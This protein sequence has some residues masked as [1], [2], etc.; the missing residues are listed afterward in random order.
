M[1]ATHA[2]LRSGD[3]LPQVIAYADL[4]DEA[5]PLLTPDGDARA[6]LDALVAGELFD[7]AVALL[8]HVLPV[9]EAVWWAWTCAG[10]SAGEKPV[11]GIAASLEATR[12]WIIEPSDEHRRA[13]M[14]A[15][16]AAGLD[17]PA[18]LAGLSAFLSGGSLAPPEAPPAPP[19]PHIAGKAIAGCVCMA[20]VSDPEQIARRF[21][22]FIQKGL[23]MA[24]KRAVWASPAPAQAKR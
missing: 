16:E 1:N 15:A 8:A 22:A 19:E 9:R 14:A 5:A 6:F 20:A 12:Q 13:A 10:E 17:S 4:S 23:E 18:G 21:P 7:D 11:P 24:D 3:T 2:V